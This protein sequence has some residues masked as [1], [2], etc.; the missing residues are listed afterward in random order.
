[1]RL[2]FAKA[3]ACGCFQPADPAKRCSP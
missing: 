2:C 1:L 3:Q